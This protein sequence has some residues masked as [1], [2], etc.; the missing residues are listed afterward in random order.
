MTEKVYTASEIQSLLGL[1]RSKTYDFI[2]MAYKKQKPFRAI[3]IGGVYR[4]VK[5][6]FDKWIEEGE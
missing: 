3:K 1:S 6:S 4:V 2:R 5:S